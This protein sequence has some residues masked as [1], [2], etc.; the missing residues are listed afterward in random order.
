[1]VTGAGVACATSSAPPESVAKA[2]PSKVSS[3]TPSNPLPKRK[4]RGVQV[5]PVLQKAPAEA[6]W[7]LGPVWVQEEEH[8]V[9]AVQLQAD[10]LGA[11]GFILESSS[12]RDLYG[13]RLSTS[14]HRRAPPAVRNDVRDRPDVGC[15]T[16]SDED[17]FGTAVICMAAHLVEYG[18]DGFSIPDQKRSYLRAFRY[19]K[20]APHVRLSSAF[21]GA[22]DA[23]IAELNAQKT[24]P[25][26]LEVLHAALAEAVLRPRAY[27]R[28]RTALLRRFDDVELSRAM[29][30]G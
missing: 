5:V 8:G 22:S 2:Q 9:N 17:D 10:R 23:L 7:D 14:F 24:F 29:Q 16:L 20:K 11:D 21:A 27:V 4:T 26:Q 13:G 1:M 12:W 25:E 6:F 3:Q 15:T 18:I 30:P 28:I 19:A